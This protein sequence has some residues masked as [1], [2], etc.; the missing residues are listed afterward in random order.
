MMSLKMLRILPGIPFFSGYKTLLLY[1]LYILAADLTYS[2]WGGTVCGTIMGVLGFLQGDG[3]YGAIR[4]RHDVDHELQHQM[5][6]VG[7]GVGRDSK[8]L[9]HNHRLASGRCLPHGQRRVFQYDSYGH[10]AR[11]RHCRDDGD[12]PRQHETVSHFSKLEFILWTP[13]LAEKS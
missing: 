1:P 6:G 3:R 5:V 12:E 10:R 7:L 8:G 4:W 2:R 11:R 13:V 9:G